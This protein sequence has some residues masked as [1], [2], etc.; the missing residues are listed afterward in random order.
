MSPSIG[1]FFDKHLNDP[2]CRDGKEHP[3]NSAEITE[4]AYR[5]QDKKRVKTDGSTDDFRVYKVA[6]HLL[7][8]QERQ[9]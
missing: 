1:P 9:H 6:V 2:G 8:P 4:N 3:G 7:D 5:K